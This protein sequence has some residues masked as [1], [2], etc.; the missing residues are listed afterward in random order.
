MR[1]VFGECEFDTSR[2]LLRRHGGVQALSLKAFQLLELLLDRRPEAI[3]KSELMSLLWPTTFVSDGSLHNLVAELRAALGD[4]PRAPRY[5]RTVPRYGYA[6]HG[7]VRAASR[8]DNGIST[9]TAEGPRLISREREWRL[10]E[11]SNIVG[12]DHDCEVSVG[13]ATVSRQHAR[14]IVATGATTV[15]DLGS[16]NGTSVNGKPVTEPIRLADGDKVRVGSVTMT[17]R[18][19]GALPS[20]LTHA[21]MSS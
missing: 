8:T 18:V 4:D 19:A 5:I 16:K 21:R 7:A 11:G 20:T 13:S 3:P 6:F 10:G 12:R 2:R 15:E 9:T 14:I 17:F 1:V